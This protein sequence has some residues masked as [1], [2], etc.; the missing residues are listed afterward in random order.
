MSKDFHEIVNHLNRK[1]C[2]DD[3]SSRNIKHAQDFIANHDIAF[4]K[5][6]IPDLMNER[7]TYLSIFEHNL[8][9]MQNLE[10]GDIVDFNRGL[11]THSAIFVGKMEIILF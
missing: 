8:N 1:N 10:A 5:V 3:N 9:V 6:N 4:Y 7:T 11:Y 2:L